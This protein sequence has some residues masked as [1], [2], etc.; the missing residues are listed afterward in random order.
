MARFGP[1]IFLVLYF[2][3]FAGGG[4][5]ARF[6]GD[7]LSN[8]AVHLTPSLAGLLARN[9][10]YWSSAYRPMGGIVYVAI[11]RLAGFHPLPFRIVCFALLLGNLWLLYRV[12]LRLT[13]GRDAALLTTL[14]GAYHAWLVDLYFSTGTI[15]E[16]LCYAFYLGAFG[17]YVSIRQA[18]K[19]PSG[20][21]LAGLMALYICALNSKEL[22]VTLPPVLLCYE[23]I[24]HR[25]QWDVRAFAR[26]LAREGR[27]AAIAA[28]LTVPYIAGKM[29]GPD[30]L[31][32][33]PA[34]RPAISP[35][36][37]L[38]T[39]TLYLNLLL[40]QDHR[41]RDRG[42]LLLLAAMLGLALWRRSRPLLF[43]WCFVLLSVLPFI[44]L[45]HYSG[46]F[47][48]L[49]LA[50]WALYAGTALAMQREKVAARVP[51]AA[52]LAG[53]ALVLAP[54]HALESRHTRQVFATSDLPTTEIAAGLER[55]APSLPRGARLY[56]ESD[57][58]PAHDLGLTFLAQLVYHDPDLR[59]SRAKDGDS[60]AGG[61]DVVLRWDEGRLT[62]TSGHA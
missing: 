32:A 25:P 50:G 5:R 12:A 36:R 61:Y 7:D 11:Y 15:Y 23:W 44:F 30:S 21:Q 38:K 48:Y 9:L 53:L 45:P 33:N 41:F 22:A 26:W 46:F 39:F 56:F 34:Y 31:A 62:R 27:A 4:V 20:R 8:L 55:V 10:A 35:L 52:L 51:P 2:F 37:Y 13:G 60:P 42:T 49:P 59:V 18:G 17:Y 24:W 14:L 43:A 40:Y 28:A 3:W 57:P 54:M 16:L 19:I 58:F 1:G 47:L 6:T 29:I